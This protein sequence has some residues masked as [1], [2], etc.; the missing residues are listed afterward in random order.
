MLEK[1]A[2]RDLTVGMHLHELGG[3][4]LEHPFWKTR[5]ILGAEDLAKLRQSGIAHC[6]IDR[7]KSFLPGAPTPSGAA[8]GPAPELAV[9]EP[10]AAPE[11]LPAVHTS[12]EE[13]LRHASLLIKKSREAVRSL[14][15]EARMGQTLDVEACMPL[16]DDIA[17]SV[18]RN[19]HAVL[20]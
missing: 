17:E 7:D 16:V 2:V 8:A 20:S 14:F 15:N 1:I 10:L 3:N 4:W 18:W 13:E 11:P 9:D 5:F 19:P 6:W 12:L